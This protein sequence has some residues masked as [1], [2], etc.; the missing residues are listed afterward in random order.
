M[1][2]L[3]AG[4]S[5]FIGSELTTQLRDGGHDVVRLVRREARAIDEVTW[6]P[7]TGRVPQS[8]IEAADAVVNLSGA[9]LSRLPWTHSYKRA[10]LTSRVQATR[11]LALA[12]V[13]ADSPPATFVSGSAVGFYG[14]RPGETL[15]EESSRG[16][17]FLSKVVERWEGAAAPAQDRTRVVF[18]RTGLVLGPGGALSPL[19]MLTKVGLGGPL[20]AGTQHWPWISRHDEAAALVHLATHSQLSGPVN[21]VGPTTATQADIGR[22]IA[23]RLG[24]P[25]WLPAP[26]WAIVAALADAGRE[27]LLADQHVLAS[28]LLADG[29]DYRHPTAQTAVDAALS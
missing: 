9:S 16:D 19:L 20:G 2:V 29:F 25:W 17:G 15:T 1:R 13:K 6:D 12:I 3:I 18:A 22:A 14:D 23:D 7:T 21:L 5:G 26:R 11:T 24:K 10:I 8:A 28:R 4:A 27:L